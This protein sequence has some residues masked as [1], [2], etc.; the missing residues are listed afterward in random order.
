MVRRETLHAVIKG[1]FTEVKPI[2]RPYRM[3]GVFPPV[4]TIVGAAEMNLPMTVAALD[5]RGAILRTA[6]PSDWSRLIREENPMS[7]YEHEFLLNRAKVKAR[8]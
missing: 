4:G 7:V 3:N 2:E 8:R 6:V 1:E 5:E